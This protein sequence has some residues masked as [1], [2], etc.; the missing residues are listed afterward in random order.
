MKRTQLELITARSRESIESEI[1]GK[2]LLTLGP[3]PYAGAALKALGDKRLRTLEE[4][5]QGA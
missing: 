1:G 3:L 5:A 4:E 2:I